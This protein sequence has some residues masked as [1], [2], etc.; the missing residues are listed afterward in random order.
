M[1]YF[2]L[3]RSYYS[4]L[5]FVIASALPFISF[6]D[7]SFVG[8]QDLQLTLSP[9]TPTPGQDVT[10]S[11]NTYVTNI[12][13]A[14]ISWTHDGVEI[15]RGYGK[16]Q[17]KI[18]VT[19]APTTLRVAVYGIGKRL[20][21]QAQIIPRYTALIWEAE[22]HAP[23]FYRGKQYPTIGAK[24]KMGVIASGIKPADTDRYIYRWTENL[25]NNLTEVSGTGRSS[26]TYSH[27]LVNASDLLGVEIRNARNGVVAKHD[28]TFDIQDSGDILFYEENING[29]VLYQRDLSAFQKIIESTDAVRIEA[30]PLGISA[31]A[32][33]NFNN[34]YIKWSSSGQEILP[35]DID[36]RYNMI[37]IASDG[38]VGQALVDVVVEGIDFAYQTAENRFGIELR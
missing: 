38:S 18:A 21:K 26:F 4:I 11:V 5:V 16:K 23:P 19:D 20:D 31:S 29:R 33:D 1:L 2:F 15:E 7:V 3:M 14:L 10:A 24:I 22:T 13:N 9:T 36:N 28:I 6:A 8:S 12:D 34:V 30:H 17:V 32:E 27:N 37:S 35:P 25:T